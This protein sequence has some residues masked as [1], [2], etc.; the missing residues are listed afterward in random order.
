MSLLPADAATHAGA[1]VPFLDLRAPHRELRE[2]LAAAY[3]RVMERGWFINGPEVEAFE[4]EFAA[5]CGARHCIGVGNGLDALHLVLRAAGIREGDEVIVPANTFIA[6]FLAVTYTGAVPVPVEPDPDTHNLDP[7]RIEAAVTPRTRAVVPVHLYGQ[8]ADMDAVREVADRHGLLLVEDAAQAHGAECRG[9]RAGGLGDAAGFS[10]YP[11]KNLGAAG[12]AGAVTTSDDRLAERIRT[13]RNYGSSTKYVHEMQGFN[14]RLDELQAA[15]LRVKLRHLDAWNARRARVA[16][17]YLEGLAGSGV[18]LP[19]VPEWCTPSWHLFVVRSEDRD[20][21][22]RR[23][24]ARGIDTLVHYPIPSH[25]Q[26]AYADLGHG[27]G[28]FPLSE[29][30]AREVL[31]LPMGPHLGGEEVE[32]V[33]EAVRAG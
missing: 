32:R 13:L 27:E 11:G 24:A 22:Q 4:A 20:G 6:T 1:R 5:Y 23:L 7:A 12:D 16:A 15:L 3:E 29:R 18:V 28:A 33:I 30:L 26:A 25:L 14:S 8:P 19:H 9:R 21:L 2:E 17:A 31:S 10:F